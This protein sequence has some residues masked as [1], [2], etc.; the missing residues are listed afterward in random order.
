MARTRWSVAAI[1][2]A[3]TAVSGVAPARGQAPSASVPGSVGSPAAST[4]PSRPPTPGDV[5]SVSDGPGFADSFAYGVATASDGPVVMVGQHLD[6]DPAV[7]P[8]AAAWH[9]TDGSTWTE[10]VLPQPRH[11]ITLDVAVSAL[12]WAA[13]GFVPKGNGLVWTSADGVTWVRAKPLRG[14]QPQAI[15]ATTGGFLAGGQSVVKGVARPV[16]WLS[17]DLVSWTRVKLP[18]KGQVTRLAQLP[19]GVI[20]ALVATVSA[21]RV[22]YRYLRSVDGSTWD[23]V[24]FPV[25]R[26]GTDT[27]SAGELGTAGDMFVQVVD[28]GPATGPFNGSVWTSSDGLAWEEAWTAPG[29]L[30]AVA[31][32]AV[33][34]VFGKG[35]QGRHADGITWTETARPEILLHVRGDSPAGR[36]VPG[37]RQH[38][39][40]PAIGRGAA[41]A[42]RAAG[43]AASPSMPRPPAA[44]QVP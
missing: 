12:G 1:L 3:A 36:P 41:G 19:S 9:S 10:V 6:R 14:G 21:N 31:S 2:I 23:T 26:S 40:R 11:A 20:L 29:P 16:L 17:N 27:L 34:N 5:T 35:V 15:I 33:V 25:T 32:G 13:I 4:E 22:T 38:Q 43:P 24:H 28:G 7:P 18:G 30:F 37:P 8:G 42:A 39:C 44:H